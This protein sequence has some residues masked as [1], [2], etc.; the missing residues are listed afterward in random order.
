MNINNCGFI[1]TYKDIMEP[2]VF[3]EINATEKSVKLIERKNNTAA[4]TCDNVNEFMHRIKSS[5]LIFTQHIHPFTNRVDLSDVKDVDEFIY[6]YLNDFIKM[7]DKNN[8]YVAQCRKISDIKFMISDKEFSKVINNYLIDIGLNIDMETCDKVI[9]L[10]IINTSLYI[11]VSN[12]IDNISNKAGGIL[13]YSK[14]SDIICR[15]EFKI[16][17]AVKYFNINLDDI[18]YALDLGAA[19]GG[20]THYLSKNNVIVDAVDPAKLDDK[21]MKDKNVIHYKMLAQEYVKKYNKEYDLLV[22]D[23]KMDTRESIDIIC[24]LYNNLKKN[25]V[26][27][28][29]LKLPKKNITKKIKEAKN[30][31]SKYFSVIKMKQLY[32]NRNEIT[33]FLQK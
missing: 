12:I 16:E 29:T 23:M 3:N 2:L 24:L 1:I 32:Y 8:F 6:S 26:C 21:L 28:L 20:W 13:F 5:N 33:V 11:G 4:F 18:Q 9:S 7:L 19:P 17:E 14:N 10:T 25:G 22:D 31:L 27:I 30:L 15:A